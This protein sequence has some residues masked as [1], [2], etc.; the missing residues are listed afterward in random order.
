MQSLSQYFYFSVTAFLLLFSFPEI[1]QAQSSDNSGY[2]PVKPQKYCDDCE[3]EEEDHNS[4]DTKP[5]YR[6]TRVN[7]HQHN[8]NLNLITNYPNKKSPWLAI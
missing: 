3:T 7:I 1:S 5:K 4:F 2:S 6:S 8:F